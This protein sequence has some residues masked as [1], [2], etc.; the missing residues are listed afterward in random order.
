MRPSSHVLRFIAVLPILTFQLISALAIQP[1]LI[2]RQLDDFALLSSELQTPVTGIVRKHYVAIEEIVWD[3]SP[4]KWDYFHNTS[5]SDSPAKLWT[6]QST[7]TLGTRYRKA[8]YREY[9]DSS[10]DHALDIPEWQGMM[11]PIFRAEVGDTFEIHVTNRASK[12]YSI[13]PHGLKYEFEM[14]GAVYQNAMSNSIAPNDSFIYRWDIPPRSG[15]GPQDGNSVVWGYHS[16]VAENDV[17]DGL[18]GAIIIYKPGRL[19]ANGKTKAVDKE[20]V[21]TLI[22]MDENRSSLFK[23][24]LQEASPSI[25]LSKIEATE[26]SKQQFID[27]NRKATINGIMFGGPKDLVL[28]DKEVADWHLLAWGTDFDA[29][30]VTWPNATALIFNQS[31]EQ[32]KLLPASFA[33]ATISPTKSGQTEFGCNVHKSQGMVMNF[34]I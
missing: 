23:Q 12:N 4:N 5:I 15:P 2:A 20:F 34:N 22:V 7:T 26:S 25:D 27:S 18:F 24:T 17:F 32:V 14:E 13:H 21:T 29:F 3:Y 6:Q 10:L 19:N 30:T 16:H 9:N 33:T 31:V 11:G 28:K 8:V 1:D